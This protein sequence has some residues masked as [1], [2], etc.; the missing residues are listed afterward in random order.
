M[1]N[2]HLVRLEVRLKT[3]APVYIGSSE[4]LT[5][6]EYILDRG[7]GKIHIPDLG[8]LTGYLSKRSLVKSFE[9]YLLQERNSDLYSFLKRN[10]IGIKDYD[11]FVSYSLDAGEAYTQDKFRGL[12]MFVK[13]PDG[14]PYIPGSS[15]KGALRTA[16][17]AYTV[18]NGNYQNNIEEI[19]RGVET[20]RN[21]KHYMSNASK[22]LESKIFRK[23]N[24]E[25]K[26]DPRKIK[27]YDMMNDFMRGISISDSLPIHHDNLIV[28]GKYDRMP[29]GSVNILNIY[30]ECLSPGTVTKFTLTLDKT[31]LSKA[32]I[33]LD[34]IKKSLKY[35]V[36]AQ[37]ELFNRYFPGFNNDADEETKEEATVILGGGAGYQS[38]TIVYPLFPD[39]QRALRVVG[40]MMTKQF[41]R[42]K[43]EADI[44]K[45][46]VSPHTLKTTMYKGKYYVMGKCKLEF[47][48]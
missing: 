3:L 27:W 23:L 31:V 14:L 5:K 38:K 13:G 47:I 26:R 32:G 6:K 2:G 9:N 46:K 35:F 42:H 16:I 25:D 4:S 20:R 43:H 36:N 7:T 39:R 45:H 12:L 29:D 41:P 17:T 18:K 40:T 48:N 44:H 15:L 30:R 19:E 11:H 24:I 8:K 21:S 37:D 33:D 34:Y 22:H 10:N 1:K 28:C